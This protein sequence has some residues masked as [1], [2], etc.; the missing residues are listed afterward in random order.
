MA[1]KIGGLGKGLGAFGLNK[2]FREEA[3]K[4]VQGEKPQEPA[5]KQPVVDLELAQIQANPN[6]PRREFAEEP[7]EALEAS[8]REYG[9]LQPVLV[10]KTA[11]GYELIAGER[12]FRAAQKAGLMKIPAIVKEYN[13]AQMTEIA[14]IENIQRENLNPVEEAAAYQQLLSGYGLTQEMLS[15]KV[16]RSRSHIANFLRLLKLSPKV[17]GLLAEGRLSMGQAKVLVAFE[18]EAV[19][20][21]A[22]DFILAKELSTRQVE[23]L[24][25][26]LQKDPE[27]LAKKAVEQPKQEPK[28]DVFYLAAQDRLKMLLGTNVQIKQRGKKQRLEIDLASREELDRILRLLEEFATADKSNNTES[29]SNFSGKFSV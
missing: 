3:E 13:D 18:D 7:L 5:A 21:Q 6:Q 1:K 14:L 28:Q 19:Q 8:I 26:E 4:P 20:E 10:R 29:F 25:K 23:A 2:K 17:Q 9:V 11:Q 12:R 27:Y 16:G 15:R 24:V 22:A